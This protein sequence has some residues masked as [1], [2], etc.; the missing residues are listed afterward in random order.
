MK[1]GYKTLLPQYIESYE[2][3]YT[4]ATIKYDTTNVLFYLKNSTD[5]HFNPPEPTDIAYPGQLTTTVIMATG[6]KHSHSVDYEVDPDDIP[7]LIAATERT[8]RLAIKQG[9]KDS[10]VEVYDW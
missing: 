5:E 3:T 7:A 6:T 1:L 9:M 8:I 4:E 2:V 10:V